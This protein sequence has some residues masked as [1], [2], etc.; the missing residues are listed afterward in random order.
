[1]AV[2]IS[3]IKC[4]LD[5]CSERFEAHYCRSLEENNKLCVLYRYK[6]FKCD[7]VSFC[8]MKD[9]TLLVKAY[10]ISR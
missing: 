8:I 3:Y 5:S 10:N 6:F 1:M 4:Q 9:Q 7:D 2:I